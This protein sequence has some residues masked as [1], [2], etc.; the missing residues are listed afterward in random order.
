MQ[1]SEIY[2]SGQSNLT[3][4]HIAAG[5]RQLNRIRQV[6]PLCTRK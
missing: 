3:K 5:H 2:T 4:G 1:H 6:A